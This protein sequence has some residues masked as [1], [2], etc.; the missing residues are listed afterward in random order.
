MRAGDALCWWGVS[1]DVRIPTLA[2]QLSPRDYVY[3]KLVTDLRA[4]SFFSP[5]GSALCFN[6]YVS[7]GIHEI[8]IFVVDLSYEGTNGARGVK[9]L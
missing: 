1:R 2:G 6:G 5:G 3:Q 9:Y 4:V 8:P 7:T